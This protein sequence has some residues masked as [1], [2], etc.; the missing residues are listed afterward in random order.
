MKHYILYG[1]DG[2]ANHGC[3]ALARTTAELLDYKTNHIT[4]ISSKAHEDVRYGLDE[5]CTVSQRGVKAKQLKRNL[6]FWRAYYALKVRG[7][8]SPMDDEAEIQAMDVKRG[9]V[10]LAI[11]GDS[12]C[13]GGEVTYQ[14]IHQHSLC[15]KAGLKTVFWGCSIEPELLEDPALA[16]DM[17]SF[18]LITARESISYEALRRVNPNTILV[19]DSAFL[20]QEK[21]LP[22]PEGFEN[23]DIV[24]INSSPLVE[25]RES[26]PGMVRRNY[27]KLIESILGETDYKILLIPHVTWQNNDDRTVH[28]ELYEKYKDTSRIAAIGDHNCRELKGFISRCRFFIGARTHATIAAYSTGVPTLVAGYSTKSK[29]IAK[30]LFGT[31]ENYVIAVQDFKTETDLTDKWKWLQANEESCRARLQEIMPEYKQRVYRGQEAVKKL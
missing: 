3:E 30:D 13:Y 2:S 11:G 9:D 28:Q 1:H 23:G 10:A 22:M 18:D 15:K 6:D 20:L 26:S 21:R 7:D 4:L 29:G 27:E 16:D 24:G 17:H 25:R 31:H 14:L 5:F 8:Y 12:Y 19:A